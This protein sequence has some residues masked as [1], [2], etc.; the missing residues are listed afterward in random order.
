MASIAQK[1]KKREQIKQEIIPKGKDFNKI[2]W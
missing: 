2:N 1:P